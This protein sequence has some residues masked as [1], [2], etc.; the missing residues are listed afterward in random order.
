MRSKRV[1][2]G[3]AAGRLGNRTNVLSGVLIWGII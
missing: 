1:R 3:C 2:E